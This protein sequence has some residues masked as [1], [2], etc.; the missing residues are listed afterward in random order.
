MTIAVLVSA[1]VGFAVSSAEAGQT[2]EASMTSTSVPIGWIVS[3]IVVVDG[4]PA[5]FAMKAGSQP[6]PSDPDGGICK[7]FLVADDPLRLT[8]NETVSCGLGPDVGSRVGLL[9]EYVK[10]PYQMQAHIVHFGTRGGAVVGPSIMAIPYVSDTRAVWAEGVDADWLYD[11]ATPSGPLLL[12]ISPRTGAVERRISMPKLFR[13][14]MVTD[15]SGLWIGLT[16][17]GANGGPAGSPIYFVPEK[18]G[19]PVLAWR[20]GASDLW[21]YASNDSVWFGVNFIGP[22]GFRVRLVRF[23]GTGLRPVENIPST[24]GDAENVI[25]DSSS[26]IVTLETNGSTGFGAGCGPTS[27]SRV[28]LANGLIRVLARLA[29]GPTNYF[30]SCNGLI[31]GQGVE[32]AGRVY[33]L[34]GRSESAPGGF[35]RL[36]SIAAGGQ[37]QVG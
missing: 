1:A 11:V 14:V 18:S 27:V 32:L 35:S 3:E 4:H 15:T 23:T 21:A 34:D 33:L 19:G 13:P 6:S 5:L 26:S 9:I 12:E 36:Y 28:D 7:L 17:G 20:S 25:G 31:D 2:P 8:T 37:G 30:S 29:A 10:G 16:P 24:L 22:S